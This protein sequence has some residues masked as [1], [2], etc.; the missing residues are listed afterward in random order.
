MYDYSIHAEY[1]WANAEESDRLSTL[2]DV[3]GIVGGAIG[4]IISV[5]IHLLLMTNSGKTHVARIL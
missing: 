3:G 5:R 4:G 2:Y 1:E